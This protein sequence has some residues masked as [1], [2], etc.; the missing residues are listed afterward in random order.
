MEKERNGFVTFGLW[1][2]IIGSVISIPV[3]IV[4][5]Q[6]MT[7]LGYLGMELIIAGIDLTPFSDAIGPHVLI[8]QVVAAISG[9]CMIVFY[10]KLLKWQK[11]GFWGLVVVAILVAVIN[12]VMINLI[13]QDYALVGLSY[14]LNPIMQII[15]TPLSLLI[16]WAVLQIKKEGISCWK[17]LE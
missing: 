6:N 1:L 3:S 8:W 16:L 10:S 11:S 13:K 5:Y 2:G 7:N 17:Q 15:A 9:I 14:N 4:T 12:V